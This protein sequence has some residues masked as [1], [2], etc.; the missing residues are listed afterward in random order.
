MPES[1]EDESGQENATPAD[2]AVAAAVAAEEAM[3]EMT[4]TGP[5]QAV[6]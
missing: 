1:D 6:L 4:E 3:M 2:D 5:Y